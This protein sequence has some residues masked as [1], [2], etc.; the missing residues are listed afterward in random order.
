MGELVKPPEFSVKEHL[1][2]MML[3]RID[4]VSGLIAMATQTHLRV[5]RVHCYIGAGSS[6]NG[7]DI[8]AT[9]EMT[10]CDLPHISS[11]VFLP[12]VDTLAQCDT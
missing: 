7:D 11:Q 10:S 3:D 4:T 2:E 12:P 9:P 6:I 5:Q 1:N 8:V